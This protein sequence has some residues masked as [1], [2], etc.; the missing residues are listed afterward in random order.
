[1]LFLTPN[2][3]CQGTE[4]IEDKNVQIYDKTE[5]KQLS[6]RESNQTWQR[7]FILTSL[8]T[9]FQMTIFSGFTNN[10]PA[11]ILIDYFNN[12]YDAF[13]QSR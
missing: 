11:Q 8:T 2:Q 1:M 6:L 12:A 3:Q 9:K 10:K 4:G 5:K 7:T 13:T